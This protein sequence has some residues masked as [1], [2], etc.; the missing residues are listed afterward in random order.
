MAETVS[1]AAGRRYGVARAT[2]GV[3]AEMTELLPHRH[4]DGLERLVAG[5]PLAHVPA[6]GFGV[7]VLGDGEELDLAVADG[8]DLGGVGRPHQVRAASVTILRS[9]AS[10]RRRC[11]RCGDSRAFSRSAAAPACARQRCRRA[12]ANGPRPCD[13]LRPTRASA[14]VRPDGGEE[15]RI[16]DRRLRPAP[17]RRDRRPR[18]GDAR[19]VK[20]RPRHAPDLADCPQLALSA[21]AQNCRPREFDVS[22]Q[23]RPCA[24]RHYHQCPDVLVRAQRPNADS[25]FRNYLAVVQG[26]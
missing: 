26:Q 14:E 17:G 12:R 6:K 19:G 20:A 25:V 5:A 11:A 4:A 13:G 2:G 24:D 9:C 1:P 16:G 22:A 21:D 8:G 18:R 7:P 23:P 10:A 3:A 15:A